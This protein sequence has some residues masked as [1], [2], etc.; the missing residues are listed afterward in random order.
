M[1]ALRC[2]INT[3]F[4]STAQQNTKTKLRRAY[5]ARNRA[6]KHTHSHTRG[7]D[8]E[9]NCV[10]SQDLQIKIRG[11]EKRKRRLDTKKRKRR[12]AVA[13]PNGSFLKQN[14]REREHCGIAQS[15][16]RRGYPHS[17]FT[18]NAK[19]SRIAGIAGHGE[20]LVF[21]WRC[22]SSSRQRLLLLRW[23]LML[24]WLLRLLLLLCPKKGK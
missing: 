4:E 14:E 22:L 3:H 9:R 12:S 8:G 17:H 13:A 16:R 5:R 1:L 6:L 7:R 11:E 23:L 21:A 10:T 18:N 2:L 24:L 15:R 19:K 20:N